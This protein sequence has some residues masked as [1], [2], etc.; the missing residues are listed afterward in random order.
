MP[1]ADPMMAKI[2]CVTGA[3]FW[4]LWV[5][6]A[7]CT[8]GAPSSQ[9]T[10]ST[11]AS[12]STQAV[13]DE[14]REFTLDLV[15]P[16]TAQLPKPELIQATL[17]RWAPDVTAVADWLP[18][19]SKAQMLP[20]AIEAQ[21]MKPADLDQFGVGL[22]SAQQKQM[23]KPYS[24]LL[25]HFRVPPGQ[26]RKIVPQA[27]RFVYE[28]CSTQGIIGD[29]EGIHFCSKAAW[30]ERM[31]AWPEVAPRVRLVTESGGVTT[32][33]MAVFGLPELRVTGSANY[34]RE[35]RSLLT[36]LLAQW[37]AEHPGAAAGEFEFDPR[38]LNSDK[39][40]ALWKMNCQSEPKLPLVI[41]LQ[42]RVDRL[43][44]EWDSQVERDCYEQLLGLSTK[45]YGPAD[46]QALE[47]ASREA[48]RE[49]MTLWKPEY[50]KGL[51][52]GES[53][54]V[55]AA[56]RKGD[57]TEWMWLEV[58]D[59]RGREVTGLLLEDADLI[60]EFKGGQKVTVDEADLFDFL[61]RS[62]ARQAGGTTDE[63]LK[64]QQQP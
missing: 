1:L 20:E 32:R 2:K 8:G 61:L 62:D 45:V 15:Y 47:Q 4:L 7:G 37:L 36:L 23:G 64:A 13:R 24:A 50:Q 30:K 25:F 12:P 5:L 46:P 18:D 22:S 52:P 14:L 28:L 55:K 48:V 31:S 39:M 19:H 58:T 9:P 34:T 38:Q 11:T 3:L 63:I 54:L 27:E 6:V 26:H 16:R 41:P 60:A 59:W 51:K 53:L 44:V 29:D 21:G 35:Y 49:L 40:R 33:G 10:P 56:F 43:T 57:H 17:A 42:R